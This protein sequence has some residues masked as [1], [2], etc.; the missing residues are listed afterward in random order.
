M[1]VVGILFDLQVTSYQG[2]GNIV[3]VQVGGDTGFSLCG[4]Q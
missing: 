4:G 1:G 3:K 2:D